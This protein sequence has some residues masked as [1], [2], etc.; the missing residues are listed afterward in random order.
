MARGGTGDERARSGDDRGRQA[1][2]P[3][4]IPRRGWW[5]ILSRVKES[6]SR[7]NLSLVSGG[8]ALFALLA[9]FPALTALLL[10]YGLFASPADAAAHIEGFAGLLPQQ[11]QQIIH[12]QLQDLTSQGRQ[13][14]GLGLV[15]TLL[16]ALWSARQGMVGLM[17]ATNIAYGER[18]ERGFIRQTLVS[19]GLT[20]GAIL[21]F[22]G[23]IV[24]AIA[25]PLLLQLFPLGPVADVIVMVLRWVLLGGLV[26]LGFA[27]VY[28]YAPDRDEP[29][30][31]WVSWGSA[32]AT[33]LWLVAS[34]L[35]ALYVRNFGSY[36]ETYGA[37]GGAIVL[38]LWF[39]ISAFVI[40][41]GAKINA[42]M[43]HQTAAD[44]TRGRPEP[45]GNRDAKVADDLGRAAS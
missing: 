30:W 35:F 40:V 6:I 32:I 7:D 27:V 36:N 3:S 15:V 1:D 17:A 29:R 9:L 20:L 13:T 18:E 19:L 44:T 31:R 12:S 42:E 38:L 11:A 2:T 45:M 22:I 41:L 26:I 43:E 8:V 23:M 14:L 28:R 21:G 10:I 4:E 16:V 39:Y 37:L 5:D 25:V 34:L 24:L 33:A